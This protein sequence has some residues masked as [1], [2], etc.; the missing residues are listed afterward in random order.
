MAG[1]VPASSENTAS[2]IW[3]G[4][5]STTAGIWANIKPEVL[6]YE[7]A[8]DQAGAEL[9]GDNIYTLT[10]PEG[11]SCPPKYATFFWSVIAVDGVRFRVLPNPL[12]RFL[13]NNESKLQYGAD[14]SLTLYFA[15]QKPADAPTAIGCRRRKDRSIG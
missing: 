15:D 10:L 13:L 5:W 11:I 9:N 6:Y 4:R 14:G 3:R 1:R 8:S 12:N 2:I 7:G